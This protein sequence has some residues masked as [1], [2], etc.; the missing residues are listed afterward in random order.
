MDDLFY[1]VTG[2]GNS[3]GGGSVRFGVGITGLSPAAY[4]LLAAAPGLKINTAG[5]GNSPEKAPFGALRAVPFLH[6]GR[7]W[8]SRHSNPDNWEVLC[9]NG[10]I[11]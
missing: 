7:T 11:F 8:P 10:I 6:L 5:K 2:K 1:L 4:L 3:A 9:Y